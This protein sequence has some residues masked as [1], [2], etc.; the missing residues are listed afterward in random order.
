MLPEMVQ[1]P[2]VVEAKFTGSFELAVAVTANGGF[3][4]NLSGNDP[5]LMVWRTL[6]TWNRWLT[7]VAAK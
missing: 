5:K 1:M 3:P 7:G 4:N 2:D 6:V